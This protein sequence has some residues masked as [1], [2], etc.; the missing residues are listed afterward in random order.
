MK[1]YN[2]TSFKSRIFIDFHIFPGRIYIRK[3][4]TFI[5]K[6]SFFISNHVALNRIAYETASMD[7][8]SE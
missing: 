4:S 3:F 7:Y 8:H 1:T 6:D 2:G 5:W